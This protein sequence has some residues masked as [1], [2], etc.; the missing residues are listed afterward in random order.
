M[1]PC[2]GIFTS[3]REGVFEFSAS[4]YHWTQG[5]YKLSVEKNNIQILQFR[6]YSETEYGNTDTL[7]FS[8][9]MEIQQGDTVRL[10]VADDGTFS[11]YTYANWTFNGKFIHNI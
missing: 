2:G 7:S 5:S 3:P 8:W 11:A 1:S 9:I 4:T 6:S 10:K